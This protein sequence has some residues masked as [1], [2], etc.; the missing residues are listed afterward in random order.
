MHQCVL[1]FGG[2]RRRGSTRAHARAVGLRGGGVHVCVVRGGGHCVSML[3]A[4]AVALGS[5]LSG[6]AVVHQVYKPDLVGGARARAGRVEGVAAAGWQDRAR[7][8][9]KETR[10][11][12]FFLC[13]DPCR[14]RRCMACTDRRAPRC[15][16]LVL[17]S[18][19]RRA[20]RARVRAAGRLWIDDSA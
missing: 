15:R 13:V 16:F 1:T 5:L 8:A 19:L 17:V 14:E 18:C 3:R 11:A 6:A 9:R 10:R 4:Y 12:L 2:A 20:C 7:A